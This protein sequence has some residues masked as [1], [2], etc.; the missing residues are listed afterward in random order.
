MSRARPN[1][2][3]DADFPRALCHRHE[4]DV[5]DSDA[6]HYEGDHRD[7]CQQERHGTLGRDLRL[8]NIRRVPSS[9][10]SSP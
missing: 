4:H 10:A 9:V 8:G 7:A 6:S 3:P 5:H 2:Q 1:R